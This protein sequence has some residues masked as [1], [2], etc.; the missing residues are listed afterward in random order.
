MVITENIEQVIQEDYIPNQSPFNGRWTKTALFL[1]P[2]LDLNLK[3][4]YLQKYL[5][6]AYLDDK[7]LEHNFVRPIFLLFKVENYNEPDFKKLS[8][9]LVHNRVYD[10][11]IGKQEGYNLVMMVFSTPEKYKEDYYHFKTG[12]YSKFSTEYK[13]KF[14]RET[15]NEK[16]QRVESLMYGAIYKTEFR[17]DWVAKYFCQKDSRDEVISIKEYNELRKE[18][19]TW[20]EVWDKADRTEYYR[21]KKK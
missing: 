17:K 6:N 9:V 3:H 16:K 12:R 2:M 20:E 13:Q 8:D 4:P 5:F 21:D 1:L 18:I 19:D 10:Y 15:I 7:E 11:D 14:P